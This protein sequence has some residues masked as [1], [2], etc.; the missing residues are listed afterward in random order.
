MDRI[1]RWALTRIVSRGTLVVVTANGARLSFG[2]GT[3]EPV[4]V[5]L[6]DRVAE[7]ALLLD[8]D[9][10]LGELYMDGRLMVERG[11][12]YDFLHLILREAQ[13]RTHPWPARMLDRA[14][15]LLRRLRLRNRPVRSQRN[16]AHHYDLDGRLYSLFLDA[17]R[18]YSCAYFEDPGQC[19]EEAQRAK[20]RHIIAKLLLKPHH[21]VLDIGSG[22]GGLALSI[23]E[24]G[25]CEVLGVTL[26]KEQ[27][28]Y[29]RQRP[30]GSTADRV[31][32]SLADY[33]SVEGRFDR[34]VSVGMFEH[35]GVASYGTFF[36]TCCRLLADDGVLLLHTIGC[37]AGPGFTTPW[38][39]KYIFPGGYIPSLSEILPA[40][41]RA[42]LTVTDIEILRLHY[43]HTLNAWRSRFAARRA[44]AARLYDER[45]CRMWEYYLAAAEVAFRCE[46]LVV[47]Q[48][49]IARKAD[50]VPL[51]R[52]YIY[53]ANRAAPSGE[54]YLVHAKAEEV[55]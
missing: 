10:R 2:D 7:I 34:I 36:R 13:N 47:F 44:E 18:Q 19:L 33:R 38:L 15:A 27:L 52:D 9:M 48:I 22:W 35:V 12:I 29:A 42:G 20:K 16:V 37:S 17:D 4:V 43:A 28:A 8:P 23:A 14:R 51:T 32:F 55:Q 21:K 26:S 50:V 3:G 54:R 40:I 1:L 5:R 24:A 30:K 45:F 49:Q 6:S 53:D 46:D 31:R 41:E 11:S 39:D 25:A